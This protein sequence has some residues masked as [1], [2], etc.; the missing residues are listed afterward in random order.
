MASKTSI[1][2]ATAVVASLM[3]AAL[4]SMRST[5]HPEKPVMLTDHSEKQVRRGGI[6]SLSGDL[7]GDLPGSGGEPGAPHVQAGLVSKPHTLSTPPKGVAAAI[8]NPD[9][10]AQPVH[11]LVQAYLRQPQPSKE[12][13][14]AVLAGLSFCANKR[15]ISQH[16]GE[17]RARDPEMVEKMGATL[18]NYY[19]N[20]T[21]LNDRD[22]ILRREIM[23]AL[24][25]A[26]DND[27]KI[28][29]FDVGPFGRWPDENEHIPMSNEDLD[30]WLTTAIA[31]MKD[32]A[33]EGAPSVYMRLGGIYSADPS[34]PVLGR[35]S[36][37]VRAYAY[38]YLGAFLI[39]KN[40]P[41][42]VRKNMLAF[43]ALSENKVSPEQ[44]EQGRQMAKEIMEN[45]NK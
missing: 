12:D 36:D 43:M 23:H 40:A 15:N 45:K 10:P 19:R 7:N 37:P 32:V 28:S 17:E 3:A 14:M 30:A 35:I 33:R 38:D 9:T 31:Y 16:I 6:S 18:Q 29:F 13:A 26:G 4:W 1:C 2:I 24:A 8:V 27:A 42:D 25:Q 21:A 22:Y 5:A 34:D 44:R 41:P 39:Q 20:C 11:L